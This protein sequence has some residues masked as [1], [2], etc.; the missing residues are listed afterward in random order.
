MHRVNIPWRGGGRRVAAKG[1][2][3]KVARKERKEGEIGL[4][5]GRKSARLASARA[6]K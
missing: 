5:G 2:N 3:G 4:E 1:E 6:K